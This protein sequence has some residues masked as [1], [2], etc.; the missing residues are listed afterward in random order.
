MVKRT[1]RVL[2]VT[3]LMAVMLLVMA[4]TAFAVAN[5]QASCSGEGQSSAEKGDVG[6][7]FRTIATEFAPGT[8]GDIQRGSKVNEN[9]FDGIFDTENTGAPGK[10]E[11]AR[12]PK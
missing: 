12:G 4:A 10:P 2:A 8:I 9:C 3:T 6:S 11:F 7:A 5:P 1:V